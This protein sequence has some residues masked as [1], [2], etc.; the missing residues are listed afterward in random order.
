VTIRPHRFLVSRWSQAFRRHHCTA[1]SVGSDIIE[2]YF[3]TVS[4]DSGF[5]LEGWGME[6]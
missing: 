1:A 3:F 4:G 5:S 2:G 6:R